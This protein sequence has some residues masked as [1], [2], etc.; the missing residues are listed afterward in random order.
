MGTYFAELKPEDLARVEIPLAEVLP[1]PAGGID[2]GF[3]PPDPPRGIGHY[4]KFPLA[5]E[6]KAVAIIPDFHVPT[7]KAREVLPTQCTLKDAIFNLQRAA[8]L[9][10]A[11]GQSPPDAEAIYLAMQDKL[12]QPHRQTLIPGLAEILGSINPST[13]PGV[14]GVCLSG[15]G[16]TILALATR[17]FEDIGVRLT[18]HFTRR[19]I[20]CEWKVLEP[21]QDGATIIR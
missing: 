16:P 3:K 14:L 9:P 15:A 7:A 20:A 19:N 4:R 8:L 5:P 17:N 18:S 21:A 13:Q 2:T 10:T 11:L 12:H 6:I 1:A